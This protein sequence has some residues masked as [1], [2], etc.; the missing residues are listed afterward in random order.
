MCVGGQR[1]TLQH[2]RSKGRMRLREGGVD[3]DGG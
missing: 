2:E 3:G 1:T